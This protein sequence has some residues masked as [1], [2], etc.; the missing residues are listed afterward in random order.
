[1][2]TKSISHTGANAS[3]RPKYLPAALWALLLSGHLASCSHIKGPTVRGTHAD[4]RGAA[5]AQE[6]VGPPEPQAI[7]GPVV[8]QERKVVLVL[9]PGMANAWGCAGVIRALHEQQ[10]QIAAIAGLEFGA[11]VGAAYASSGTL[12]SMD[13]K[14]L[15]LKPEWLA[16]S[17]GLGAVFGASK[18]RSR[19]LAEGL[20]KI[21]GAGDLSSFRLPLW[22]AGGAGGATEFSATGPAV[23]RLVQTLSQPETME[24]SGQG[25]SAP[26]WGDLV[27]RLKQDGLSYPKLWVLGALDGSWPHAAATRATR[28][29]RNWLEPDDL[30]IEIRPVAGEAP[31][32]A[33]ALKSALIYQG[34]QAAKKA[35]PSWLG[36]LGW[37]TP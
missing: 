12:P 5:A 18:T 3:P 9:G 34:R 14:L 26:E 30:M 25:Y 36:R 1:M 24:D 8:P 20:E 11:L 33:F 2:E 37:G 6:V 10:I 19:P 27:M 32:W 13:W 22:L 21:F 29:A 28:D 7:Q 31:A 16:P 23:P 15:Q 17:G 4:G 35:L